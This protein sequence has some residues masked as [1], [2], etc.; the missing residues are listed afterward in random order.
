MADSTKE[1]RLNI[2]QQ[3]LDGTVSTYTPEY[4]ERKVDTSK[5]AERY[6]AANTI[7]IGTGSSQREYSLLGK[8]FSPTFKSLV[9]VASQMSDDDDEETFRSKFT[10]LSRTAASARKQIEKDTTLSD[11]DRRDLLSIVNSIGKNA[12][13][14]LTSRQDRQLSQTKAAMTSSELQDYYEQE[15]A[16][17][18]RLVE[19]YTERPSASYVDDDIAKYSTAKYVTDRTQS[20]T[21]GDINYYGYNVPRNL[22]SDASVNS[23][24]TSRRS[25]SNLLKVSGFERKATEAANEGFADVTYR[26]LDEIESRDDLRENY[27]SYV[28]SNQAKEAAERLISYHNRSGSAD[29]SGY[30]PSSD[31]KA[32]REYYGNDVVIDGESHEQAAQR[33]LSA[34]EYDTV[35]ADEYRSYLESEGY[36]VKRIQSNLAELEAVER[37]RQRTA[38]LEETLSDSAGARALYNLIALPISLSNGAEFVAASIG[39]IGRSDRT[40][41]STYNPITV[42][43]LQ[44]TS[45]VS[46]VQN[47]TNE[48]FGDGFWGDVGRTAYNVAFSVGQ[49]LMAGGLSAAASSA[50]AGT[51]SKILGNAGLAML[52]TSAGSTATLDAINRGASNEQAVTFGMASAIT[53]AVAEY[54]PLEKLANIMKDRTVSKNFVTKVLKDMGVQSF[55]EATEESLTEISN[56]VFDIAVMGYSSEYLS[57]IENY[58]DAGYTRSEA[59]KKATLD[60]ISNVAYSG[61]VG[62]LSGGVSAAG[63]NII[64]AVRNGR[65]SN[66][67]S[68]QDILEPLESITNTPEQQTQT[69]D[70]TSEPPERHQIRVESFNDDGT[71]NYTIDG[72][73]AVA[74][75]ISQIEGAEDSVLR[76][77]R[78]DVQDAEKQANILRETY[79][80]VSSEIDAELYADHYY[81]VQENA[82]AGVEKDVALNIASS[83]AERAAL[84]VAYDSVPARTQLAYATLDL[85]DNGVK[86][87][88][89]VRSISDSEISESMGKVPGYAN[90]TSEQHDAIDLMRGV[91]K[92]TGLDFVLYNGTGQTNMA[93]ESE[94][95][96]YDWNNGN[97]YIDVSRGID[98]PEIV[99][100]VAHEVTHFLRD[101]APT[102]YNSLKSYVTTAIES[103]S[104]GSLQSEI[105]GVM[106]TYESMGKSITRAEAVDEVVAQSLENVMVTKEL[107]DGLQK[108]TSKK[109]FKKIANTVVNA[110]KRIKN[111]LS[112][113][114]SS[115]SPSKVIA[116]TLSEK[117]DKVSAM[118]LDALDEASRTY[119]SGKRVQRSSQTEPDASI[120]RQE[121]SVPSETALKISSVKVPTP[122][123]VTNG[124]F[125][126]MAGV[127]R[128]Y[129]EPLGMSI[130]KSN[131]QNAIASAYR[132]T[133]SGKYF[134]DDFF[135]NLS[136]N[137]SELM[138]EAN[139]YP[140]GSNVFNVS[141][142]EQHV[143]ETAISVARA[144]SDKGFSTEK[145]LSMRVASRTAFYRVQNKLRSERAKIKTYRKSISKKWKKWADNV[146]RQ[147]RGI[148]RVSDEIYKK[149]ANLLLKIDISGIGPSGGRMRPDSKAAVQQQQLVSRIRDLLD[150]K[151]LLNDPVMSDDVADAMTTEAIAYID[152]ILSSE[153]EIRLDSMSLV[154]LKNLNEAFTQIVSL[155]KNANKLFMSENAGTIR[156]GIF[157]NIDTV[158]EASFIAL[159]TIYETP[160]HRWRFAFNRQSLSSNR[161]VH[162]LEGWSNGILSQ[163]IDEGTRLRYRYQQDATR[164]LRPV[165]DLIYGKGLRKGA[166]YDVKAEYRKKSTVPE[167]FGIVDSQGH[168]V[169]ITRMTAL[170]VLM[171]W[172]R[173]TD[174]SSTISN[175]TTAGLRVPD[176]DVLRDTGSLSLA[177][178]NGR[179]V[180]I[181]QDTI[182]AIE[183]RLDNF[184]RSFLRLARDVLNETSSLINRGTKPIF[185]YTVAKES[186]Y[187]TE[188]LYLPRT[189]LS[190][191]ER[192][193]F[194]YLVNSGILKSA[195]PGSSYPVMAL[196][197]DSIIFDHVDLASKIG[198][199]AEWELDMKRILSSKVDGDQSLLDK[200]QKKFGT[201]AKND[202]L[203][204][205][206]EI[207]YGT[208]K[209]GRV[210]PDGVMETIMPFLEK[211]FANYVFVSNISTA[212]KQLSGVF[213]A[214]N[215]VNTL[216][217]IS[218]IPRTIEAIANPRYRKSLFDEI[219]SVTPVLF[220]RRFNLDYEKLGVISKYIIDKAGNQRDYSKFLSSLSKL[221][222]AGN[223]AT[224]TIE[225]VTARDIMSYMDVLSIASLWNPVKHQVARDLGVKV[226]EISLSNPHHARLVSD[227]FEKM[228]SET[229]PMSDSIYRPNVL[230]GNNALSR[231]F[232]MFM[233]PVFQQYG[234]LVQAT[235]ELSYAY[236]TG[237][238][239]KAK[240]T[241]LANTVG[242]LATAAAFNSVIALIVSALI[243]RDVDDYRDDEGDFKL[244]SMSTLMRLLSDTGEEFVQSFI[245]LLKGQPFANMI[246]MILGQETFEFEATIPYLENILDA[247]NGLTKTYEA[248]LKRSDDPEEWAKQLESART[249]FMDAIGA[250]LA[251]V[252]VPV[253][254]VEKTMNGL[255][256]N[257]KALTSGDFLNFDLSYEYTDDQ[258][259]SS[260]ISSYA[261]GD[262]ADA[263]A[264]LMAIIDSKLSAL[265]E[266]YSQEVIDNPDTMS[267]LQN[268]AIE[269]ACSTIKSKALE[270]YRKGKLSKDGLVS[271]M[272]YVAEKS[273]LAT[274]IKTAD[275]Y[276]YK[277]DLVFDMEKVDFE[278]AH[279]GENL[280]YNK[281]YTLYDY[282]FSNDET[283]FNRELERLRGIYADSY[284]SAGG[285]K[286]DADE[287]FD[288]AYRS[289][290]RSELKTD[291]EDGAISSDEY[292]NLYVKY[293]GGKYIDAYSNVLSANGIDSIY[294][295][296][297]SALISGNTSEFN[298]MADEYVSIKEKDGTG[299]D[300][301]MDTFVNNVISRVKDKFI[302]GEV[303]SA[304]MESIYRQY[305]YDS[306]EWYKIPMEIHTLEA[307]KQYG[308][309]SSEYSGQ[310][311]A[312]KYAI[313][314]ESDAF[315]Q[316]ELQ[317]YLD[318]GDRYPSTIASSLSGTYK[319]KIKDMIRNGE[320]TEAYNLLSKVQMAYSYIGLYAN[321]DWNTWTNID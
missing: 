44:G 69:S 107:I 90:M 237:V 7:K 75:D 180:Q 129:F 199:M 31:E 273:G 176:Y 243:F 254:Q 77:A 206:N 87:A 74:E 247:A 73:E 264:K 48:S 191:N 10:T 109:Q 260:V 253:R 5:S 143:F 123:M 241:A 255:I 68:T 76:F 321:T 229:Q 226:S 259:A 196:N 22:T 228:V 105:D 257:I 293:T 136:E 91:A 59:Q 224:K 116:Q 66:D 84:S 140:D 211:S 168:S 89:T 294:D 139:F 25:Q 162:M 130:K 29:F 156:A 164:I 4:E 307:Q 52:A 147:K 92:I 120:R 160:D 86:R 21:S 85:G 169:P 318:D 189:S 290:I 56:T 95:G 110:L 17:W 72:N 149:M 190:G 88:G 285:T 96:Y 305:K 61:L 171:T 167:D 173:E 298:R 6:K 223:I 286:E 203:A 205:V 82:M 239:K 288:N 38:E 291:L 215:Y 231:A 3:I 55:T 41:L 306:N 57:S 79:D 70:Q 124:I 62:G 83:D 317:W 12:T 37:E 304:T 122:S 289:A 246:P 221:V 71:V 117:M 242:G 183:S 187:I 108:R 158:S 142:L 45:F 40:D 201:Q 212:M 166:A 299:R 282:A 184:D 272:M 194:G 80:M 11:D 280:S 220:D 252:G 283:A 177:M 261:S 103:S 159:N 43:D 32:V 311:G 128:D 172:Q 244:F 238:G 208:A 182:N 266:E 248:F 24:L 97:V 93:G 58:V 152:A 150:G 42:A 292:Q 175:M 23:A 262:S 28:S 302:S 312:L 316:T 314:N 308:F 14:Q 313:E 118:W 320:T 249:G 234:A 112:G 274:V 287:Y 54:I 153:R 131:L 240:A 295:E 270:E 284:A 78:D 98:S 161:V 296:P 154:E 9:S 137:L 20:D 185:G 277:A 115:S 15:A 30:D 135:I 193:S 269:K 230:K 27:S 121:S 202:V 186:N 310:Y 145:L 236:K 134:Q 178:K 101:Y 1:R 157:S 148:D 155:V 303:S 278:K 214:G 8:S 179:T 46:T 104:S 188:S 33:L 53:E 126:D 51:A 218:N 65:T 207:V 281:F 216:D 19:K 197:L 275:W 225:S 141:Q 63:A 309:S 18:E 200:I 99:F 102:A 227:L 256:E 250:M 233:S 2:R 146:I 213:L 26:Q 49:S 301:A 119:K 297:V 36:D 16:F 217:V 232:Y 258:Y 174:P 251:A 64:S 195:I 138:G 125:G 170:S 300:D 219:D 111:A 127:I 133:A 192:A 114:T 245:P 265:T 315:I 198:N 151:L 319:N 132:E 276:R 34:V 263:E 144:V 209:P 60:A 13:Q 165:Y 210:R 106:A 181:S 94:S 39:S 35:L 271:V 50:V 163:Y 235:G 268:K 81:S 222:K 113:Q 100:T 47:A 279:K 267:S 67:S 204:A